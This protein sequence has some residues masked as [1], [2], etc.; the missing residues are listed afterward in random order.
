MAHIW[1]P[2][3][4]F[5]PVHS[6]KLEKWYG[7]EAVERV[8][9]AMVPWYGPGIPVSHIPGNVVALKGGD[10]AGEM[11]TSRMWRGFAQNWNRLVPMIL[12]ERGDFTSLSDMIA[13][14]EKMRCFKFLKVGPTGVVNVSSSIILLGTWPPAAANAPAAP[15]GEAPTD[16]T[17][18]FHPFTNPTTADSLRV[19]SGL[20][21]GSVINNT[22][23]LF[24]CI[25]RVNKTMA[26]VATEA[27]TGVPTRYQGAVGS[28]N[29]P[30]GN[31]LFVQVGLTVLPAT[32]H[33]WT[34]CLYTDEGGAAGTMPSLTGNASAI[35][36]RLDHP[37]GQ[38]FAPLAAGDSGIK[39]L[40]QM[41]CS[42]SVATGVINFVMG[43]PLAWMMFPIINTMFPF[44]YVGTLF[45]MKPIFND[46]ALA[47]L[48]VN[49][50]AVTATTYN[51]ILTAAGK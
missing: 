39:T 30:E 26:S 6:A 29:S 34:V 9:Q 2:K 35:V 17:T 32:A 36:H 42:A 51:L 25:F 10:F 19:A 13:N 5:R 18:G 23:L 41:Q 1:V 8:S 28:A 49:K 46:A 11:F 16:A 12:N 14:A 50:P 48:E 43:H 3:P 4:R 37:V 22:I 38:W 44:D 20:G 21:M 45:N 47:I 7:A 33:N 31:F 27:V 15:G 40:T 24:D